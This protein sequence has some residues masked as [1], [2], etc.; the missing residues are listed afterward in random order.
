MEPQIT[1]T[2]KQFLTKVTPLSKALAAILFIVL[3]FVGLYIGYAFAPEKVV[4]VEKII[5]IERVNP[6]PTT[7][8]AVPKSIDDNV[9]LDIEEKLKEFRDTEVGISFQYPAIWG[10]VISNDEETGQRYNETE[11]EYVDFDCPAEYG[12]NPCNF[13]TYRFSELGNSASLFLATKTKGSSENSVGR[14]AFWGDLAGSEV[15]TAVDL[16]RVS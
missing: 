16:P 9:N 4:E 3:P 7:V 2:T 10:D 13:R 12:G 15:H 8:D 6:A 1:N 11:N 5:E 14:G